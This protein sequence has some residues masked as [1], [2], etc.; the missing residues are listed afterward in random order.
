VSEP[1]AKRKDNR[2]PDRILGLNEEAESKAIT[3][4]KTA[5]KFL[6]NQIY[7]NRRD[8]CPTVTVIAE[9]EES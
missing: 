8:R 2:Y 9:L 6:E 4:A 5:Q 3:A 7:D 1:F